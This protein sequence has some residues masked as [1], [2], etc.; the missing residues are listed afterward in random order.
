MANFKTRHLNS[1]ETIMTKILIDLCINKMILCYSLG[2]FLFGGCN[3]NSQKSFESPYATFV[4]HQTAIDNGNIDVL[5]NTYS[6]SYQNQQIR[7]TWRREWEEINANE[8]KALLERE[9]T[10]EKV[11]N[12][13][14]AYLLL[15]SSTLK[16]ER[17]S[18]FVYFVNESGNWKITTHLDSTFHKFLEQAIESGDYKLPD[19]QE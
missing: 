14:I 11:I 17:E 13:K 18:P 9:I 8:Q 1:Y 6:K 2:L 15:D 3:S 7:S 10:K 5:W 19:Q 12:D 4:T 16:N